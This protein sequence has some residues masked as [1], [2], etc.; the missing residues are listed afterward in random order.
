MLGFS[1]V[2]GATGVAGSR[3]RRGLAA[4]AVALAVG[5]GLL[6]AAGAGRAGPR[7][8][9]TAQLTSVTPASGMLN[10][11]IPQRILDTRTTTGG[12]HGKI[13]AGATMTLKVLG[14]GGTPSAGVS[15]VMVNVTAVDETSRT[16][17][18]TLFP[19]GISRPTASTVNYPGQCCGRQ[20]GPGAPRCQR[21]DQHLQLRRLDRCGRGRRGLGRHRH[22]LGQHSGGQ[23]PDDDGDAVRLLDTRTTNGGHKAPLTFNQSLTL[24]VAGVDGIPSTGVTA[25]WANVTAIPVGSA[26]GY[27]TAYASGS[28]VPAAAPPLTS[29]PA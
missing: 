1:L 29:C 13:G 24:Q 6:A 22:V 4:A 5:V 20:P 26:N 21:H 15:A 9:T 16:G 10:V 14:A 25:V 2:N 23:W 12:H 28:A 27:L 7:G 17:Y 19:S 3:R 8:R 11:V 18:L